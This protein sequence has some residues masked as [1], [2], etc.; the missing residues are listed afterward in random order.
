[1]NITDKSAIRECTSCSMCSAVCPVDAISIHLDADGFYR[2]IVND[3]CIDCGLCTKVCYKFDDKI[4]MTDDSQLSQYDL[5]GASVKDS[6]ILKHTT[7][8]G[9]ADVLA[10]SLIS[11]GYS[12][13]GVIYDTESNTAK[14]RIAHDIAKTDAFK[15][16]KYIQS[17]SEQAFKQLVHGLKTNDKSKYAIFGLP[18]QIYAINRY[19]TIRGLRDRCILIDLYCHGCPSIN[20]WKKY[21][22]HTLQ[23][24]GGRKISSA[25]FRSKIRGWGAGFYTV[26]TIDGI[27]S[28]IIS[29]PG[30][31]LFF[32]LFFSNTILNASCSDCKLRSTLKY[33]DIR[34]G[35]FWGKTYIDNNTGV[36]AVSIVSPKGNDV[37]STIK[38]NLNS[39]QRQFSEMLPYQ[40]WHHTYKI[41]EK[42]RRATLNVLSDPDLTIK[43]AIDTLRGFES[44]AQR[45]KRIIKRY[46]LGHP[47]VTRFLKKYT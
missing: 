39:E 22:E 13:I 42:A 35:D 5:Y 25:V 29:K 24:S 2:P 40:S 12:C 27:T 18:C 16:S 14:T 36:S 10:K 15:G 9:V 23:S 37:W 20:V 33:T 3:K 41:N 11:Q 6:L 47:N 45:I 32:E 28:P 8:G 1:M 17:Y 19:L 44:P 26:I 7:S 30:K 4:S 21:I 31:D 46:L 34:L 38:E 43:D